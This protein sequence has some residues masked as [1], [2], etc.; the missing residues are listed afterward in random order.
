MKNAGGIFFLKKGKKLEYKQITKN[1]SE[2][3][4]TIFKQII[5]IMVFTA[6]K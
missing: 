3:S 2:A 1:I 6:E 5:F 4:N